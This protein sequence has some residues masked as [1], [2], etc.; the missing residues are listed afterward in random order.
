ME[1]PGSDGNIHSYIPMFTQSDST[2][3]YSVFRKLTHTNCYLDWN[4]N[5]PISAKQKAVI[6][7]LTYRVKIV[8][9]T[10]EILA[11]Q[12]GYLYK[13]QLKNNYPDWIIKNPEK[14]ST[15]PTVNPDTGL[16][17]SKTIFIS[18][19]CVPGLSEEFRRFFDIPLYRS[20]SK[21]PIPLNPSL[22]IPKIKSHHTLNKTLSTNGPVQKKTTTRPI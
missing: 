17:V 19:P 16:E 13:V 15:T 11:K 1:V 14:K 6:Q 5:H 10:P 22:C 7:A 3:K 21:E 18:T 12:M 8:S 2:I 20:S 9:S 4:S